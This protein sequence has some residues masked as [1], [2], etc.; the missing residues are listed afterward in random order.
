[1][2]D[3]SSEI[4]EIAARL[5][6]AC[7]GR[8]GKTPVVLGIDGYVSALFDPLVSAVEAELESKGKKV[9]CLPMEALYKTEEEIHAV[10]AESLPLN[11]EEDPVL[12]FGRL[13]CGTIDDLIDQ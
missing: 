5:A 1:M 8:E 13:Y 11:Y 10:T 7:I 2:S 4:G 6:A 3:V 9:L 12:L